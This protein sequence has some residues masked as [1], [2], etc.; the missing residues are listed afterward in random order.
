MC[1]EYKL[2]C[3]NWCSQLL[4]CFDGELNL[5]HWWKM[6]IISA[7]CNMVAWN[8]AFHD[9]K[10]RSSRKRCVLVHCLAGRCKSQAIPTSVWNWSFWASFV[11]AMLK[12]SQFVISE[13]DKVHHRCG[14][15]IQQVL[16]ASVATS[17]FVLM[18]HFDVSIT[19]WLTR[20][21]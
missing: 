5:V 2:A 7:L 20:N 18:A 1:R 4:P 12:L 14:A 21:I 13:P 9:P 17:M 11:A 10:T 19:S 15:A 3:L 6:F 8:Q 16:S